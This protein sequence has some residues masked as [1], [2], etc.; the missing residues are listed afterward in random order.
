MLKRPITYKDFFTNEEVTEVF[1]FNLTKTEL[2]EFEVS[3]KT[4]FVESLNRIVESNDREAIITE[5]KKIILMT[6]GVRTEDGDFEKSEELSQKFSKT[7]AY[8]VLFIELTTND[9][10]AAAFINGVVPS[11]LLEQV[12]DQDKPQGPPP[13]PHDHTG[14]MVAPTGPIASSTPPISQ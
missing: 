13:S 6:Y 4:G 1:Y 3:Y 7:A 10:A 14:A 5:F 8:D 9:E 2:I 11:D 12:R